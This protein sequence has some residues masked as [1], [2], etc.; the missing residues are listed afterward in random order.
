MSGVLSYNQLELEVLGESGELQM[1]FSNGTIKNRVIF[2]AIITTS[3]PMDFAMFPFDTQSC[4]FLVSS[5]Y[6][7]KEVEFQAAITFNESAQVLQEF[8]YDLNLQT[9]ALIEDAD[10]NRTMTFKFVGFNLNL[11]RKF[12]PYF[13]SFYIPVSGMVLAASISF[14][15][16]PDIVPGRIALLITLSLVMISIFNNVQVSLALITNMNQS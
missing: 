8:Y 6:S 3:C 10:D 4:H 11:R 14:W 1:I 2:I 15:I 16:P 7:V 12:W 9:K 5:H 13:Y